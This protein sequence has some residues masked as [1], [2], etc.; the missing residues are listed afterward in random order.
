[1]SLQIGIVGLPNVGKST[2][3]NALT[4][5]SV[6]A[7]NYPFATIDPNVGVVAVPDARLDALAKIEKSEK[8]IP[9]AIEFVD[10]AGLV[11]GAHKG[12][13]LGNKFLSHIRDV[14]A[15]AEVVRFFEDSNILHVDGSVDGKRDIE[16][17]KTEM[18]LADLETV[19]KSL[20]KLESDSK[21]GDKKTLIKLELVKKLDGGL[22]TGQ[23]AQEVGFTEEQK[24]ELKDLNLL[25][26]KPFLYIANIEAGEGALL[27]EKG[28]FSD[29]DVVAIDVKLE[30]EMAGFSDAEKKEY[31]EG[32]G[33]EASGLDRLIKKAY[34]TLGLI[35]FF[36]AGP[37]EARAWTVRQGAKA[38]EAA[39][40]IH[41]DFERGFIKAE[42][43]N[44]QKLVEA[45]SWALARDQGAI[46]TEGKEYVF[47]DGDVVVF[48]FN[49]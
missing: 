22:E 32:E 47:Q 30:S 28:T 21:S 26:L 31:L 27:K 13:G 17:I 45:G 38:P 15:I 39:G 44:W 1:M 43:I 4:K 34:E 48:K 37:K 3:F 46:R 12:E 7:E 29:L 6:L 40:K 8:I 41:T 36:T 42:V 19:K 10:I 33:I 9:T 24:L 16:T 11:A 20:K 25:T 14:D 35:T 5:Q 18:I 49:V 23:M 2:L